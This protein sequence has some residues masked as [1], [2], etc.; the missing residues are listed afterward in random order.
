MRNAPSRRFASHGIGPSSLESSSVRRVPDGG[1]AV[2]LST[3]HNIP[4]D[5]NRDRYEHC[6]EL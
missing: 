1:T 4:E 2:H 5:C 6:Y 3:R